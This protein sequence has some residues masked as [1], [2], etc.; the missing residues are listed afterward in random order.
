MSRNYT[1][2]VPLR[3]RVLVP[4]T[5]T[6]YLYRVIA[7]AVLGSCLPDV[8]LV[9][10]N[11]VQLAALHAR[12]PLHGDDEE[13]I[14]RVEALYNRPELAIEAAYSIS[15]AD[16][17]HVNTIAGSA[18]AVNYGEILLRTWAEVLRH[19]G[20][21]SS[22][23]FVD[24]GSGRGALVML[25]HLRYQLRRSIGVELS[26]ERHQM[27][28]S[29]LQVLRA[30][31]STRACISSIELRNEDI[32]QTDL[33]DATCCLLMNADMP[34]ALISD[35]WERLLALEH[36]CV[37]VT[38]YAPRDIKVSRLPKREVLHGMPQ[39]WAASTDVLIYRLQGRQQGG[40]R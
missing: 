25:T 2:A 32:R 7:S 10:M 40:S 20:L 28:L 3:L 5:C 36:A 31:D 9:T 30:D 37:V 39:T 33:S 6:W 34:H 27:A 13:A 8:L 14:R 29:A 26:R 18:K 17:K 24:L 12:R 38:L 16:I 19:V 4:G 11:S 22:D 21:T 35:V 1:P 23:V 15:S